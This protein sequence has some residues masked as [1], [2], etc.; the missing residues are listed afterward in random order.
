MVDLNRAGVALIELV[1]QP[2]L[3]C[4]LDTALFVKQIHELLQDI[5]VCSGN[6]EEGVMR[7]DVNVNLVCGE[8]GMAVTPRVEL[9]NINGINIIESAVSSELRRQ[10]KLLETQPQELK[11]ETRFYSPETDSTVLLRVKDTSESYRYLPEYDLPEYP[12]NN[13]ESGDKL[14]FLS[15]HERI[16]Q[17]QKSHESLKEQTDLLLRLW[18]R[19]LNLPTLFQNSL[20]FVNDARFLLNWCVGELLGIMNREDVDSISITP[21]KFANLIENVRM[22][23][24]DKEF[25]KIELTRA[26]KN[27]SNIKIIESGNVIKSE[28]DLM[29]ELNKEIDNLFTLHS[30]RLKFLQS[31]E[32]QRRGA[33]VDFF[34]GPLM[35]RFRGKISAV[36]LKSILEKKINNKC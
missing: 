7:I 31:P 19:P 30:N 29:N 20:P 4:P 2:E 12:L 1:S 5:Q 11:S 15:R 27:S 32:G 17:F 9:K 14:L 24:I 21:E 10:T 23:R 8:T 3:Q 35:K 26:L 16:K 34:I 25:A 18:I 6:L 22:G 13:V 33:S 28:D 36:E